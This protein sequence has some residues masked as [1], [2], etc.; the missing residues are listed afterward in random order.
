MEKKNILRIVLMVIF[1]TLTGLAIFFAKSYLNFEIGKNGDLT[2]VT[3][4]LLLTLGT[5]AVF[6]WLPYSYKKEFFFYIGVA[7]I[8]LS[9]LV[10]THQSFYTI[11]IIEG[12]NLA[13]YTVIDTVFQAFAGM[14]LM[15]YSW[16]KIPKINYS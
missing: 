13:N 6:T 14:F 7:M 5:L 4:I 12:N 10:F 9:L 16:V 15:I 8:L 11:S 3:V 2:N 1:A